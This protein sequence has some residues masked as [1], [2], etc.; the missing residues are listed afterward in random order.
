MTEAS[1][2]WAEQAR[3]DLE[4]ASA[5]LTSRRYLYV[6]FCCQQA[7]EKALKGLIVERTG[8]MPPRLHNLPKLAEEAGVEVDERGLTFLSH[9]TGFYIQT[10]YP[11]DLQRL[12]SSATEAVAMR[13]LQETSQTTEWLLSMLT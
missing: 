2:A 3:Y 11:D 9:L 7:V 6:V 12:A 5:M 10:R 4:T 13:V 1:R 8:E